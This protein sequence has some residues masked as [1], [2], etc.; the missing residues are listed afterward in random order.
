MSRPRAA[1]AMM[2]LFR[3]IGS[4]PGF[5]LKGGLCA[6]LVFALPPRHASAQVESDPGGTLPLPLPVEDIDSP[7]RLDEVPRSGAAFSGRVSAREGALPRWSASAA[8]V[9][10][11]WWAGATF[12]Y[13]ADAALRRVTG[14]IHQSRVGVT[15]VVGS[16]DV[17]GLGA[18]FGERLEVAS[19]AA[20]LPSA[21]AT[22]PEMGPPAS[23]RTRGLVGAALS[24]HR[25]ASVTGAS[26]WAFGGRWNDGTPSAEPERLAG[27]G[28]VVPIGASAIAAPAVG[29]RS[30][31]LTGS[32]SMRTRSDAWDA[33]VEAVGSRVG[34]AA[35]ADAGVS[36]PPF[37]WRGRWRFRSGD[38][39]PIAG[40]ILAEAG[41]RLARVAIRVSGGAS[42]ATGAVER[43]ELEGRIG[44]RRG[45]GPL[46]F[47][48]GRSGTTGFTAAD[49]FTERRERYA[50]MDLGVARAAGRAFSVT[51]T[52]RERETERGAR[53]G[54]SAG[55]R[56]DLT[57][58]R[59]ARL[60]I[61]VE[62]VRAEP[63]ASAWSSGVYAGGS[64]ALRTRTRSGV[65][66]SAR[67]EA[68]VGSWSL[69]GLVEGRED[70]LG[71]QATAATIWIERRIPFLTRGIETR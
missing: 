44:T 45:L 28:A 24:W 7:E 9:Y 11:D 31:A 60:E 5:A 25:P 46:S 48:L 68:R 13:D 58:R 62:A 35:L 47:R 21:R 15:A 36:A 64:T 2:R 17:R 14:E 50:V 55:G 65:A 59:R 23:A 22:A 30:G 39:R 51:A 29:V 56:L 53:A 37:R 67:G 38:A 4:V 6:F 16:V 10:G 12:G 3:S 61:R 63:G 18:L 41:W 71:R 49:G 54:T 8:A 19:R 57:W 52:R 69:G 34:F 70:E 32:L 42:G 33:G 1:S 26:V 43:R 20:R 27:L 66:A 40:E